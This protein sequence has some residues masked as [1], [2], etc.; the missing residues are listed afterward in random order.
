MAS[1]IVHNKLVRDKILD[2]ITVAGKTY[3]AHIADD[4]EYH[5]ALYAKI[6]EELNEFKENPSIEEAADIMEV[7]NSLF[8]YNG[9]KLEDIE[10][11]RKIK[12]AKRGGF[13]KRFVLDSVT[14]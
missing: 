7:V 4:R 6:I 13:Q 2:I 11:M 8:E 1:T 9:F 5:E 10:E 3:Q 14:G 12:A